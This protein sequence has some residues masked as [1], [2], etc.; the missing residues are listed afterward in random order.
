[1]A[2]DRLPLNALRVF[3]AVASRL[4]FAEAAEALHVTA[5]AVSM[6]VKTLEEYLQVPLFLRKG[7]SV[8][9]TAEGERLLPGVRR[10]LAELQASMQQLREDRAGGPLNITTIASFLQKWLLPRLPQFHDKYPDIDLRIHTGRT[11]IDF[12]QSNF[13]AALRMATR[14]SPNLHNEK[15]LDE[16]F[17]PVCSPQLLEKYGMLEST[18]NMKT[19]PLLRSDDEPW[20]FWM[21]P[22]NRRDWRESGSVF[23]DSL[24]V[25]AAAEQ[26]QGYALTRWSLA[27]GDLATGRLVRASVTVAPC[28]RSYYFVC[29]EAYQSMPKVKRLRDWLHSVAA[30]FP[31]PD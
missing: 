31:K 10:G 27:A 13:H 20:D 12:S 18:K 23:D 25:L 17:L 21:H 22:A 9:L 5:A 30:A 28:P 26:G 8:E 6:Q 1:M 14:E 16:W 4:S 15:L 29:P 2:F 24:T 19:L 3:E 11:P 7:R